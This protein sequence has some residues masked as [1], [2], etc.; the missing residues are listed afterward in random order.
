MQILSTHLLSHALSETHCAGDV[1]LWLDVFS[2]PT[3]MLKDIQAVRAL[4]SA[5]AN[6]GT[7]Q[8]P[9]EQL[10]RC[11]RRGPLN[12]LVFDIHQDNVILAW[13]NYSAQYLYILSIFSYQDYETWLDTVVSKEDL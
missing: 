7:V 5:S 1:H 8:I 4:W 6:A 10:D 11:C 9:A 3:L 2:D 13:V 12:V